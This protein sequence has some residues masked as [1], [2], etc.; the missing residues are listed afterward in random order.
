MDP[1]R[2]RLRDTPRASFIASGY[3]GCTN[4]RPNPRRKRHFHAEHSIRILTRSSPTCIAER[5]GV[6][7]GA[8][9][10]VGPCY[11]SVA[12]APMIVRIRATSGVCRA[13]EPFLPRLLERNGATCMAR[14]DGVDSRGLPGL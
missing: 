8:S 7:A 6:D 11:S 2:P 9:L 4:S 12:L 1:Q 3:V 13:K 14:R 10:G 5:D